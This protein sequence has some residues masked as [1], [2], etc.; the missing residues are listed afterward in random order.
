MVFDC[1]DRTLAGTGVKFT[2]ICPGMISTEMTNS[3]ALPSIMKCKVDKAAKI[4]LR[5]RRKG[6]RKKIFLWRHIAL[7]LCFL[8]LPRK[9]LVAVVKKYLK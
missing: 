7:E 8:M 4:I 1:L 5:A 6:V 3:V 2:V 9:V